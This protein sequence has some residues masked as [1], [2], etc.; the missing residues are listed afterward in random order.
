MKKLRN[1]T[2]GELFYA[3]YIDYNNRG[4]ITNISVSQRIVKCIEEMPHFNQFAVCLEMIK[5][6]HYGAMVM[7]SKDEAEHDCV[8][9]KNTSHYDFDFIYC[10]SKE[11]FI[12]ELKNTLK[13]IKQAMVNNDM[14][15]NS[16]NYYNTFMP[17]FIKMVNSNKSGCVEIKLWKH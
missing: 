10:F 14:F 16:N 3:I 8:K 15:I 11:L 5:G 12:K 13:G 9:S 6:D 1:L 4:Q 7:F 2:S 17:A